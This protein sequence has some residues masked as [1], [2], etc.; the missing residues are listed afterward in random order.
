[1]LL[2]RLNS[3]S[4][5]APLLELKGEAPKATSEGI[6]FIS[7]LWFIN[8]GYHY[9]GSRASADMIIDDFENML[10]EV[11]GDYSRYYS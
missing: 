7:F 4:N 8:S 5:Y 11:A 2:Y 9:G 3:S 10:K 1:M 6:I